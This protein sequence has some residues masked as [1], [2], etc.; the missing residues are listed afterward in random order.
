MSML[1]SQYDSNVTTWSPQGRLFQLEYAS[2]AVNQG[3]VI[4]G[5]TGKTCGVLAAVKRRPH[6]LGGYQQKIWA[7]D[8]HIFMGFSGL[9]SDARKLHKDMAASCLDHRY[10][11]GLEEGKPP[12]RVAGEIASDCH[13]RTITEHSRPV[14]VGVLLLGIKNGAPGL[15][16]IQPDGSNLEYISF[17]IGGRCQSARTYL[18]KNLATH[19]DCTDLDVLIA[20]ALQSVNSCLPA[21]TELTIE[22]VVVAV[23]GPEGNRLIEGDGLEDYLNKF[24]ESIAGEAMEEDAEEEVEAAAS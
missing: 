23:V 4:V 6:E 21:E 7:A 10:Q 13:W 20:D 17:A 5:I 1:K 18:E 3:S 16:H 11:N 8:K 22:N 15:F 12:I 9:S 24:K 19:K 2:E 14:G